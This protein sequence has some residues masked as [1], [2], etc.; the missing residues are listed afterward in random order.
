MNRSIY[1]YIILLTILLL[2]T[3]P[4]QAA[5][6]MYFV[7]YYDYAPFGWSEN[8]RMQGIYI[9]IV[10]EAIANRLG[11]PVIHQG[12]PWSR[13]QKMIKDGNADGY[14]TVITPERLSFSDPTQLPII[15]VNFKVFTTANHSR[16][17]QLK[18]VDSLVELKGFKLVDYR[19][20]GWAK[21]NLSEQDV[22]WLDNNEQIWNLLL[23]KRADASVKNEWTARHELNRQ[24]LS[25][26]I[27]EMP[28][29]M[30]IQPVTF[31]I[32][33]GKKSPYHRQLAALNRTIEQMQTDGT[34][35]KILDKY[36]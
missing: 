35:Q 9:D 17:D 28:H 10:N 20:S 29:A 30:N 15:E 13:A 3:A 31:H 4:L 32:F 22:I 2:S 34:L 18:N 6:K 11:I 27:I 19:G 21:D 36:R 16:L 26:K 5:D 8:G 23:L 33:I 25:E 24:G 1:S 14:C 12:L 7:Y